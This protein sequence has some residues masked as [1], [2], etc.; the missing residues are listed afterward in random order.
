M[1]PAGNKGLI[2]GTKETGG[3]CRVIPDLTVAPAERR[4]FRGAPPWMDP[5]GVALVVEVTSGRP[6]LDRKDKR[7]SYALAGIPLYLLVDREMGRVT[8]FS[9]PFEGDYG[10]HVTVAP[11]AYLE[12][13]QPFGFPL[14]TAEFETSE[15]AEPDA[16][17]TEP[18]TSESGA[19]QPG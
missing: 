15:I 1:D 3:D 17:K 9:G 12:L 2:L 5:A 13:P 6:K 16:G 14:A 10:R 19:G 8:L 7:I 4:L 11:G 18:G